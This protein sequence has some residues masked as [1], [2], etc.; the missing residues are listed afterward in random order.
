LGQD[1]KVQPHFLKEMQGRIYRNTNG[2]F[3]KNSII[4]LSSKKH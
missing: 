3:L 2:I 1:K 4:A